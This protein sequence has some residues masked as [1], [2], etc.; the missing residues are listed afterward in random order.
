MRPASRFSSEVLPAPDDPI[1][2]SICP[3]RTT[4][5]MS[6][7][8]AFLPGAPPASLPGEVNGTERVRFF[9]A[10]STGWVVYLDAVHA[11]CAKASCG[12]SFEVTVDWGREVDGE[13]WKEGDGNR[14]SDGRRRCLRRE[15]GGRSGEGLPCQ[16]QIG[17]GAHGGG[18]WNS[19]WRPSALRER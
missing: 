11:S 13:E 9:Q 4:P 14:V 15:R 17:V 1:T 6:R 7:R 8:M 12:R 10:R 2:A 3:D 5:D 19:D 18:V 16:V